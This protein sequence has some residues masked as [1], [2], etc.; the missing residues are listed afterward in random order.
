MAADSDQQRHAAPVV[1]DTTDT[2]A[3]YQQILSEPHWSY[4]RLSTLPSASAYAHAQ[5]LDP[6]TVRLSLLQALSTY[7]GDHGA[8]ISIDIL[9]IQHG[10]QPS[11]VIVRVPHDDRDAFSA[12]ISSAG[13]MSRVALRIKSSSDWLSSLI[14]GPPEDIFDFHRNDQA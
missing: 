7:L 8:A 9:Q 13:N 2:H 6:T 12:A 5:P 3:R 10:S 14:S 1:V 4:F 11:D